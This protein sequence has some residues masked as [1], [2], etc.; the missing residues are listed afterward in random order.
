[1]VPLLVLLAALSGLQADS[2]GIASPTA[3][4]QIL[5]GPRLPFTCSPGNGALHPHCMPLPGI[6]LH[7]SGLCLLISKPFYKPPEVWY[8]VLTLLSCGIANVDT[9]K[10]YLQITVPEKIVSPAAKRHPE[11][12]PD[13]NLA[14]I[15]TIAGKPY[16]IHLK[17]QSFLSPTATVYYY[18]QENTKQSQTLLGQV[19][20]NYNGYIA[21]FPDSLVT[22]NGSRPSKLFPRSLQINIVVEKNLVNLVV[23]KMAQLVFVARRLQSMHFVTGALVDGVRWKHR[24]DSFD[25][26]GSDRKAVTQ[27]VIQI[28]GLANTMFAQLR[29]SVV[30]NSIEIWSNNNAIPTEGRVDLMLL[31]FLKWNHDHL[32]SP[33]HQLSYLLVFQKNPTQSGAAFPGK[34]CDEN[35]DVGIAVYPEGF[36]LESYTIIFV[37]VMSLGLGLTLDTSPACYCPRGVCTMMPKAVNYGGVKEFSTCNLEEF[38]YLA[39]QNLLPCLEKH[40]AERQS[41]DASGQCGNGVLDGNEQCDCGPVTA[42][43]GRGQ[44]D[45]NREPTLQLPYYGQNENMRISNNFTSKTLSTY[46]ATITLIDSHSRGHGSTHRPPPTPTTSKPTAAQSTNCSHTSCC[47]PETCT[48]KPTAKCGSGEC[49][50][51]DCKLQ[52]VNML[53]RKS[54]DPECDF[55]EFCNGNQ[56][57]CVPDTFVRNG[58]YCANDKAYCYNGACRSFDEQCKRLLGE[59]S[60]LLNT[61]IKDV[62]ARG[63]GSGARRSGRRGPQACA[64]DPGQSG[65]SPAAPRAGTALEKAAR[66]ANLLCGKLVCLWPYKK[67]L[68]RENYSV[69]YTH[70]RED[71]CVSVFKTSPQQPNL[72]I[73]ISSPDLRDDTFVDDGSMCG[74]EMYC[75]RMACRERRFIMDYEKCNATRDCNDHGQCNNFDHCHCDEGFGPPE[76]K[77]ARGGFG[78]ID[79]GHGFRT[80]FDYFER[81]QPVFPKFKRQ[82]AFYISVPL[83]AIIIIIVG[84]VKQNNIGELCLRRETETDRSEYSN[85]NSK[86]SSI[87]SHSRTTM[88]TV[89]TINQQEDSVKSV[90]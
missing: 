19:N 7:S 38:K 90:K 68:S 77:P 57:D 50:T 42:F 53:C 31:D 64:A 32:D 17:K 34:L 63:T 37:Q 87:E 61:R 21:G 70:V 13:N 14:Y 30:I 67:L 10:I 81:S 12:N 48:L 89:H 74:P 20:C 8:L 29:L 35:Y 58:Q 60:R 5:P 49:C 88:N 41:P 25:Y 82:L 56:S 55:D 52:S 66:R 43:C 83:L 80:K 2:R 84:L 73:R 69:V 65:R 72:I 76:C 28:I 18:D 75:D 79:D 15:I 24:L 71:I 26:M 46:P 11:Y 78:S 23:K 39:S 22:L 27:K 6:C 54:V 44:L 4:D 86:I 45:M 47:N 51:Q 33:I 9:H 85:S 1:M 16:F 62:R 59:A 3:V 40:L 36:S